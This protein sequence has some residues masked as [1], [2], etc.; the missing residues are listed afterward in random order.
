MYIVAAAVQCTVLA[1]CQHMAAA[2]LLCAP[3]QQQQQHYCSVLCSSSPAL[4]VALAVARTCT[5]APSA[6]AAYCT[7][8]SAVKYSTGT[9]PPRSIAGG[10]LRGGRRRGRGV[11][12]SKHGLG[13][14]QCA[15]YCDSRARLRKYKEQSPG[16][17]VLVLRYQ[18]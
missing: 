1:P 11:G 3:Q 9:S 14:V 12:G 8:S 18:P 2:M 13:K 4:A 6:Y 10:G 17:A 16:T 5:T 15:P 7:P